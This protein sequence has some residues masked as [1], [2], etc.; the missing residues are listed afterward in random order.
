MQIL[1]V[2]LILRSK[3]GYILLN[4]IRFCFAGRSLQAT[5]SKIGV[6]SVNLGTKNIA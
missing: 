5:W 3:V 6:K 2:E 4:L 1:S